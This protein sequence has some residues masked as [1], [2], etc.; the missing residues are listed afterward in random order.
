MTATIKLRHLLFG[1][2]V[3]TNLDTVLKSRHYFAN[4]HPYSQSYGFSCS[5][6]WMWELDNKEGWASENW[7]FWTAVWEKTLESSL[8]CKE[9]KPVNPKGNHPWMFFGRTDA[10]AEAPILW[11][12]D[13]E[14]RYIGKDPDAGKDWGQEEKGMT[15]DEMVAWHYRLE[16]HEFEQAPGDGEGQ[17]SLV[18]FSPWFAVRHEWTTT[19]V[20][21]GGGLSWAL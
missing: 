9:I 20:I 3:M 13:D 16:E 8:D 2:K 19:T 6:V 5:Q 15:E 21:L 14:S 4:K 10:E 18:C 11:P 17:R 1:R 12:P 7:C